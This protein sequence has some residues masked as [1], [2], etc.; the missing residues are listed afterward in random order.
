VHVDNSG[1]SVLHGPLLNPRLDIL[2]RSDLEHVG[3][4]LG[5]RD[6]RSTEGDVGHNELE[7]GDDG[8]GLLGSTDEDEGSTGAEEGEVAE[9]G[10]VVSSCLEGRRRRSC[11][12]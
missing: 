8:E 4:L 10:E 2:L 6:A 3:D 5:R 1:V 7:G 11:L 9:G 12:E